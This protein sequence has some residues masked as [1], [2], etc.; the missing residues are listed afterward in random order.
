MNDPVA[1]ATGVAGLD[2]TRT[3]LRSDLSSGA[4]SLPA[5]VMQG[6]AH[7]APAIAILFTIQFNTSLAG[8]ASPLSYLIAFV[9]VLVLG[10]VL[11]QLAKEFPSAGGYYTYV[12]RTVHP[13]VGFIVAW[14]FVLYS[15]A[16]A[17]PVLSAM[18]S[19][20]EGKLKADYSIT[21][22]WWVF[23]IAV[24]A[25]LAWVVY[26]GIRL[27]AR[28]MIIAVIVEMGIV[29]LL[30]LWGLF[31]PGPGG[32]SLAPYNP[33]DATSLDGLYLAVVFSIFA[34][35]GWEAAAPIAEE[36]EDPRRTVPR[37]I[38]GSILVLG[39]F[40]VFSSWALLVGWGVD[41][42]P[43]LVDSAELPGLV[44]ADRFWGDAS[45]ILLLAL[46]NSVIAGCIAYVN[47]ATRMW[48]AMAR[49]GSL[50]RVLGTVHPKT[51][52]PVAALALEIA[53]ILAV[54]LGLGFGIG[55]FEAFVFIGIA[56]TLAMVPVYSMGNL[57]VFL[58]YFRERRERFNWV[59]HGLF[60]LL[61]TL[62]LIWVAYKTI[63]PLPDAP[64][65]KA[66]IAVI[67]WLVLGLIVLGT[68]N[69]MGREGWLL[70]AG[71][72]TQEVEEEPAER[73]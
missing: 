65:D 36:S 18:G 38:I 48:Y 28:T 1:P 37:G 8:I 53:L 7:I 15:P 24:T 5:V 50:P 29:L 2:P 57:G 70:K 66:P 71:K 40:L 73:R 63:S 43:G 52:A 41:D 16:V 11:T 3:E 61:G 51:K 69:R 4:L 19:V 67:V 33:A 60:P 20:I 26:R 9:I 14:L 72:L 13:R 49:S 47:V 39:A 45:I 55:P 12:S 34:F 62:A 32:L 56:I 30:A 22:P 27:S 35:T 31:D 58:Y 10:I 44:L 23:L 68:M 59:L 17:A 25:F 64:F 54:G 46:L 21:L 42:V 6:I